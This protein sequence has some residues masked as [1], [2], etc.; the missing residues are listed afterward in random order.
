MKRALATDANR[1]FL[2][3]VV[4]S[5][6]L[7]FCISGFGVRD[8]MVLQ[9]LVEVLIAFPAVVYLLGRQMSGKDVLGLTMPGWKEWLLLLP[10]A[11]CV[12]KIA[13]FINVLSQVVT[14]NVVGNHMIP[15]ILEY[16]FPVAFFV[17]AVM[18]AV[19]EELV[20]RG[21]LYRNY[22]KS[23]M[24]VGLFLSGFL[25]GIMHMNLN[26]FSYAFVLGILLALVNEITGS[27]LPAMFLHLYINGRSVVVVHVVIKYLSGLRERY[28]AAEAAGDTGLMD[29]L[30]KMAQGVPIESAEWLESYINTENGAIGET[31]LLLLPGVLMALAGAFVVFKLLLK[32]RKKKEEAGTIPQEVQEE[33]EE[34][35]G[36]RVV[37]SPELFIG[38]GFCIV[39]MLFR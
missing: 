12:D 23:G 38:I 5:Q 39:F 3:S 13:E 34:K 7:I 27:M 30:K 8:I 4:V 29:S 14:P 9:F 15:L 17:I 20:Y 36:W 35:G 37:V 10:L 21:V 24:V 32:L 28:V 6:I 33:K 16:P 31:I 22:R 18:P 25:F 1:V 19:C 11:V 2:F 26:Q